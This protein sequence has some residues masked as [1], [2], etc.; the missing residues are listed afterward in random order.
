MCYKYTM[1][2]IFVNLAHLFVI[3]P[4]ILLS[5]YNGWDVPL[6]IL[7]WG[8]VLIHGYKFISNY[9]RLALGNRLGGWGSNLGAFDYQLPSRGCT[10]CTV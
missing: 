9:A 4:V 5:T 3:G 2:G 10:S 7:G 8:V 1:C 6:Y